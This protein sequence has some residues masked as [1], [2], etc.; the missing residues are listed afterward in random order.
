MREEKERHNTQTQ[1]LQN[2]I[3]EMEAQ[4]R[5]NE[6]VMRDMDEQIKAR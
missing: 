2:H 6:D 4:L 1:Q 3:K 5:D